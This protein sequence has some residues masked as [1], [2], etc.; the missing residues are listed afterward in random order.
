MKQL[1]INCQKRFQGFT[2]NVDLNIT[3]SFTA[4]FGL[5]GAGKTTLLNLIS[6]LTKVDTG[7]ITWNGRTIS[8]KENKVHI[9]PHKRDIG[10]IFQDTKLFPHK[11]I[12]AN[13]QYGLKYTP[14]EKKK[15]TINEVTEVLGLKP[16]LQRSPETLSGGERQKVALGMALLASPNLL[17]LDEPLAALDRK[18]KL[19][20]L[21]YLGEIHKTF[22]LPILYVSHDIT[23]IINFAKDAVVMEEGAVT[24]FDEAHSVLLN[25]TRNMIAGD[26]ENI[27]QA[28]VTERNSENGLARL[29]AGKFSLTVQDDSWQIGANVMVEIP[30]SEIILAIKKPEGLSARNIIKGHI[31]SIYIAGRRC[32]VDINI[33]QRI[34]A[35]ILPQTKR[36]LG[37]KNG[38]E[39][40]V[41]I[42]AKCVHLMSD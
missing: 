23:A 7:I 37:L 32:L 21:S 39:I 24:A 18:T 11:T 25:N 19:R 34:T 14:V 2:L 42:K 10:Y 9:P 3:P 38:I 35:E 5:S 27:F 30:S 26:V 22:N 29:D 33:G 4:V 13:L 31:T 20:F 15:F 16:F 6:G 1:Y 36:E 28:K 41:I 40:Y 8:D 17:L 12:L